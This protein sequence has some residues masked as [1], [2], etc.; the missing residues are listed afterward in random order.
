MSDQKPS[1]LKSYTQQNSMNNNSLNI[2]LLTMKYN[3]YIYIYNKLT[4]P[5][6]Y[7]ANE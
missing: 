2:V 6:Y 4:M 3:P 1:S 5:K 7:I